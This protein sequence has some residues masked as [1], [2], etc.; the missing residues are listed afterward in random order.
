MIQQYFT[1]FHN[2]KQVSDEEIKEYHKQVLDEMTKDKNCSRVYIRAGNT[3]ILGLRSGN[4][5]DIFEFNSGYKEY[6]YE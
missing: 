5:I 6:S 4:V 1:D 3:F 2:G